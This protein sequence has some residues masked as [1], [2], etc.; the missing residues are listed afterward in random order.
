[1]TDLPPARCARRTDGECANPTTPRCAPQPAPPL[2]DPARATPQ[3]RRDDQRAPVQVLTDPDPRVLQPHRRP[4]SP[5]EPSQ[6]LGK[7]VDAI[8]AEPRPGLAMQHP[9]ELAHV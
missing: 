8:P 7:P 5:D 3:P 2:P 4:D 9:L 1:M 6:R